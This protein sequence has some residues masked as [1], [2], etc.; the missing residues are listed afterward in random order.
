MKSKHYNSLSSFPQSLTKLPEARTANGNFFVGSSSCFLSPDNN[1][2]IIIEHEDGN[3]NRTL[4]SYAIQE[5]N[6]IHRERLTFNLLVEVHQCFKQVDIRFLNPEKF[7]LI[8]KHGEV[9]I[10]N[11]DLKL[12]KTLK[13]PD[14]KKIHDIVY[15]SSSIYALVCYKKDTRSSHIEFR[16]QTN[17]KT[18]KRIDSSL[19]IAFT[20]M[21]ER[22]KETFLLGVDN[23]GNYEMI[24]SI[25][26][27]IFKGKIDLGVDFEHHKWWQIQ[28]MQKEPLVIGGLIIRPRR[29]LEKGEDKDV[30]IVICELPLKHSAN[31]PTI[32]IIPGADRRNLESPVHFSLAL[33]EIEQPNERFGAKFF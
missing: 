6:L 13:S 22:G 5:N 27:I 7:A 14:N 25:G 29:Y 3:R 2:M 16:K 24:N 11:L 21:I 1:H 31:H 28:V 12:L 18:I 23:Y 30:S 20:L 10:Y 17:D 4:S 8:D 32:E 15:V 33:R 19:N 26:K 9:K